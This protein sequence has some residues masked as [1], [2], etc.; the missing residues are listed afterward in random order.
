MA[1]GLEDAPSV[2]G[3]LVRPVT[4]A[5]FLK[6]S[7]IGIAILMVAMGGLAWLTYASIDPDGDGELAPKAAKAVREVPARL[8]PVDL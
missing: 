6:R 5:W 2:Q 1:I 3:T 7:L 4:A 8:T